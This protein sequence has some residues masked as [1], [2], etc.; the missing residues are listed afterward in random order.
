MSKF[1]DKRYICQKSSKKI[2]TI[3]LI[4]SSLCESCQS[5]LQN[6]VSNVNAAASVIAKAQAWSLARLTAHGHEHSRKKKK[7]KKKKER[8]KSHE[9]Y[10]SKYLEKWAG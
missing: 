9:A 3:R 8:K 7:K 6:H 4:V 1:T 10:I 5:L 2:W